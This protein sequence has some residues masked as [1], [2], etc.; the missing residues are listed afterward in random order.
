MSRWGCLMKNSLLSLDEL[1]GSSNSLAQRISSLEEAETAYP[2]PQGLLQ[3]VDSLAAKIQ[4]RLVRSRN[5]V[6]FNVLEPNGADGNCMDRENFSCRRLGQ[7]S[8]A[9]PRPLLTT[10]RSPSDVGRVVSY[11]QLLP[12]SVSVALDRTQAQ[13]ENCQRLKLR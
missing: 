4:D 5:L 10:L 2:A 6:F 1:R 9:G 7:P 11:R 3:G 13:R 12:A 8:E